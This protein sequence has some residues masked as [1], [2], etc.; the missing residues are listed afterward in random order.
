M[1]YG[2][3]SKLYFA[4]CILFFTVS[5][6]LGQDQEFDKVQIKIVK[7]ADNVHMLMGSGGNIGVCTGDDGVFLVDNQFAPLTE[8]IKAAIGKVSNK[9]ICFLINTHWH[10]DHVGGNENMGE[11]GAVIIAHENVRNRMST[12]QFIDFFQ[13]Q[14]PASPKIALPIITFTQDLTFHLNENEIHVFHVKNAHTDGDAIV[15]FQNSNV[16]HTGDI[17]FAGLYPFI[18]TGSHGSVNG[19]IDAAKYVLSII[20]DDTKV[21]PGHGHLSNKVEL[22]GYVDMLISLRDKVNNHISEG[23]T[24]K[25]IQAAKPTQEFDEKWGHG[26]LSPDQFVQIL[27]NDLSR[28]KK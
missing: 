18:D 23:K 3:I 16:I 26:F 17:Y 27:Y 24:L 2:R 25:E 22:G 11:A 28:N 10:F 19:V 8:K 14:I 9:D 21:I 15:Y 4:F 6:A 5:T 13:K 20:N 12:D 1:Y 7:A